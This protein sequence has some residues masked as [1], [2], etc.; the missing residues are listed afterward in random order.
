MLHDVLN[1]TTGGHSGDRARQSDQA[2][3]ATHS[4]KQDF[5]PGLGKSAEQVGEKG[6]KKG[7]GPSEGMKGTEK[8]RSSQ[9]FLPF[10]KMKGRSADCFFCFQLD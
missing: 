10:L 3:V 4:Q 2:Q 5:Q 9:S 1:Q 8:A 6:E 7:G